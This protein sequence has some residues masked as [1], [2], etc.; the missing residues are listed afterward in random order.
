MNE[1]W[2]AASDAASAFSAFVAQFVHN[3]WDPAFH[4]QSRPL[5][6]CVAFFA[7]A[8]GSL[9]VPVPEELL[10]STIGFSAMM[11]APDN[12]S[13]IGYLA[14][15]TLPCCAAVVCGDTIIWFLG[16]RLGLAARSRF[17]F[18]ARAASA[19]R[20]AKV[21]RALAHFGA[22]VIFA[23]RLVPGARICTFFVAGIARVPLRKFLLFDF[24]GSLV[25]VPVFL[26]LGAMAAHPD[27]GAQ[28]AK[29]AADGA[30]QVLVIAA[31][32]AAITWGAS[33]LIRRTMT[34]ASQPDA[35]GN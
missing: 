27:F 2:Q 6:L 18:I 23:A 35:A 11:A 21:E 13:A 1:L 34:A 20:V 12:A 25:S 30:A 31:L 10:V 7:L 14:A 17:G 22:P 9:L 5:I 4:A 33:G 16:R 19:Q 29:G 8:T 15:A 32:V 28:W 24:L 26:A 3:A